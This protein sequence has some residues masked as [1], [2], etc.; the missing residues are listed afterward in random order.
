VS[1]KLRLLASGV[2]LAWLAWWTDWRQI[3]SAFAHLRWE[4]WALAVGLYALTQT[5]SSVRWRQLARPLGFRQSQGQFLAYY[6]IGMLFNNLLPT[7]VGGDVVRAWYLDH[8]PGRRLHAFASVL[9]DRCSGVLVLI[10]LA[11]GATLVCPVELPTRLSGMVWGTAGCAVL[12][13]IGF[14]L[15]DFRFLIA[16]RIPGAEKLV[17]RIQSLK[18]QLR[19]F[20]HP[21]LLVTSTLLS[22]AVQA[23][24]VVVVWLVGQALR[25]PVPGAYYGVM[26]PMVTLLTLLPSY[27]GVGLRE[28]GVVLFLAPLG[29]ADGTAVSLGILWYAVF[30]ATS[31]GGVGFYFFGRFPRFEERDVEAGRSVATNGS[32]GS[33]SSAHKRAACGHGLPCASEVRTDARSVGDHSHQGR[34]GQSPA[35]A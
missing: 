17:L 15:V 12:A 11:C 34:A 10:V 5:V 7:S 19:D 26:V 20:C 9:A 21:R 18:L 24:N 23:A 33:P 2:V 13:L 29:V 8:R 25:V 27:N 31:L 3:G 22:V 30:T 35:A 6:F 32:L 16:L 4:L 14:A 1:K 28:G